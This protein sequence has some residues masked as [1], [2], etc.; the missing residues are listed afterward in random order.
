MDSFREDEEV[1]VADEGDAAPGYG[2]GPEGG[3]VGDAAGDGGE[4]G[5][6]GGEEM[7]CYLGG[8]DFLGEGRLKE[9]WETFLE[10]SESCGIIS[11]GNLGRGEVRLAYSSPISEF[12]HLVVYS[13]HLDWEAECSAQVHIPK[14]IGLAHLLSLY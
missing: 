1:D 5:V 10:D 12:A 8:E 6:C 7:E 2:G 4:V 3:A 9:C 14:T 13:G 11:Y